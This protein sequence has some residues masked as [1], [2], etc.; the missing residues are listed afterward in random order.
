[1]KPLEGKVDLHFHTE[2]SGDSYMPLYSIIP[3][4]E[5]LGLAVIA[6]TDHDSVS[7]C[8]Y[9]ARKALHAGVEYIPAVELSTAE[10]WHTLG[11]Y[12]D[13]EN[14]G[15]AAYTER[16]K[17]Y[18]RRLLKANVEAWKDAGGLLPDDLD[19]M[20]DF[21]RSLRPDGEISLKQVSDYL[22]ARGF[23]PD[24][25]SARE[26]AAEKLRGFVPPANTPPPAVEAVRTIMKAGGVAVFAHPKPSQLDD[27]AE[28]LEAGAVG[29]GGLN[30]KA[31][32]SEQ[33]DFWRGFC[34]ANDLVLTGGTDHHGHVE[35][36]NVAHSTVADTSC[37]E[38]LRD[39]VRRLHG[40]S[41]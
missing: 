34:A 3:A 29:V 17:A 9:L 1:M 39:A 12:V 25:R 19:G 30:V 36:W 24:S 13:P 16:E 8:T 7:G 26:D 27:V 38:K 2:C 4:A 20:L 40:R 11:Y 10:H 37:M 23:Y 28:L 31:L 22:A 14:P 32:N 5:R 15:L 6:K 21:A 35:E 41:V 18:G 33:R